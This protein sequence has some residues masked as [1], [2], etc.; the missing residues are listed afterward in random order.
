MTPLVQDNLATMTTVCA[1]QISPPPSP[2]CPQHQPSSSPSSSGTTSKLF[3]PWRPAENPADVA[4]ERKAEEKPKVEEESARRRRRKEEREARRSKKRAEEAKAAA[5]NL[6]GTPVTNA[7]AADPARTPRIEGG[8]VVPA[9]AL[10][11]PS[12]PAPPQGYHFPQDPSLLLPGLHPFFH[13]HHPAPPHPFSHLPPHLDPVLL[14]EMTDAELERLGLLG[15]YGAIDSSLVACGGSP[16]DPRGL[17]HPPGAAG[18]KQRPKKYRCP[19]CQ[20]AFSNN[21]QLR[22]H[23]RIHTGERPFTCEY[24]GCGKA[25][26]R[27]EELTR[28]RRIHSGQRPF[29]CPLCDKRFGRKDH[30]KKHART[31]APPPPTPHPYLLAAHGA[32]ADPRSLML[33]PPLSYSA[34][35]GLL[36]GAAPGTGEAL[37]AQPAAQRIADM[38]A[39]A[40]FPYLYGY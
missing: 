6:A 21:G 2:K 18:K 1:S 27:N 5:K 9:P 23:V 15:G 36:I 24:E 33:P 38:A 10:T 4:E 22:G 11:S 32:A 28:H 13:P 12:I 8:D 29:A 34:H 16:H 31:H 7:V 25:F 14:A 17:T 40:G 30:L 39:L 3:R 20:V 37:S 19:H 26:T 35:P